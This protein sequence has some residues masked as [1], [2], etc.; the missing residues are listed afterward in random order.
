VIGRDWAID[1]AYVVQTALVFLCILGT[2]WS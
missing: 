1:A 2:V